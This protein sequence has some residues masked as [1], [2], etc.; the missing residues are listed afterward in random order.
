MKDKSF[1]VIPV[2]KKDQEYKVL[3]IHQRL[4]HWALP[5]GHKEG[6]E[7]N[8]EA[9]LRELAEETGIEEIELVLNKVFTQHYSFKYSSDSFKGTV[10]KT[11]YYYVGFL[12]GEPSVT[13]QLKEVQ[14]YKWCTFEEAIQLST[15]KESKEMLWEVQEF[16]SQNSFSY[17]FYS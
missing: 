15:Y 6:N 14:G 16:L 3:L 2:I 1:G 7:S 10:N 17:S 8:E 4:G 9:A 12:K 13:V 5:K 11:V